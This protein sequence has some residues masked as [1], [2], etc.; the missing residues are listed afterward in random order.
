MVLGDPDTVLTRASAYSVLSILFQYPGDGISDLLFEGWASEVLAVCAGALAS[1]GYESSELFRELAGALKSCSESDLPSLQREYARL[2]MGSEGEP[3][4]QP[5]S[6]AYST[7]GEEKP[8]E[9]GFDASVALR[10][11]GLEI[12]EG[13]GYSPEHLALELEFAAYLL[14]RARSGML[15]GDPDEAERAERDFLLLLTHMVEWVPRFS[16]CVARE[17][18][19]EL[20]EATARA[21]SSFVKDEAR[22]AGLRRE[23]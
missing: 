12:S 17:A 7:G 10:S 18:R 1:L 14:E 11:W 5:H 6:S 19:V 21:L 9:R 15:E 3:I 4:C 23:K 8:L 16:E 13:S 22:F 2:F 20:Y